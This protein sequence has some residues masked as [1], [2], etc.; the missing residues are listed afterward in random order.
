[1]G[2]PSMMGA[3]ISADGKYVCGIIEMGMGVFVGDWRADNIIYAVS[4]DEDAEMRHVSNTGVAI[5]FDGD[6]CATFSIAEGET[7]L[8]APEGCKYVLG[9]DITNDGKVMVGS[10]FDKDYF[11][12]GVFS[13]DGNEWQK[14]PLDFPEGTNLGTYE[15]KGSYAK[16]ISGD[17]KVILGC[18]GNFGPAT[19]WRMNDEG[20][21]EPDFIAE[22]YVELSSEDS[23]KPYAGFNP[24]ALSDNGKYALILV[25]E[26]ESRNSYPAVYNTET[27]EL[28]V[29]NEEQ[30]ADAYGIGLYP[31]AIA[32]D[33]TFIGC[34]GQ[35]GRGDGAFIMKAGATQAQSFTEAF[36]DCAEYFTIYDMSGCHVPVGISADGRYIIAYGY[37]VD[38]LEAEEPIPYFETYVLDTQDNGQTAIDEV[39]TDANAVPVEYFN[40]DGRVKSG[41][42]KGLNIVRMSD[43]SVRK[44]IVK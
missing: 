6:N 8:E 43:G 30:Q 22:K 39:K 27:G 2:E 31:S 24:Q 9:E 33:G 13:K 14:L 42:T 35:P 41:A 5:G 38:D 36:T 3:S 4:D 16:Y 19:L 40:I 23:Q 32:N 1:M 11:G 25:R 12:F 17:G 10:L 34:I 37:T 44:V 28:N 26:T 21:Y 18:L 15:G 7:F 29:Y 20:T